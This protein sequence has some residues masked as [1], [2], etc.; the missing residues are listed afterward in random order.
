[1]HSRQRHRIAGTGFVGSAFHY[2]GKRLNNESARRKD[3]GWEY[4]NPNA[5]N[6]YQP[7]YEPSRPNDPPY[8]HFGFPSSIGGTIRHVKRSKKKRTTN[9][10]KH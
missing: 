3:G 6:Q 10:K 2:I 1:M 5:I 7:Y 9:R 8:N 4:Y